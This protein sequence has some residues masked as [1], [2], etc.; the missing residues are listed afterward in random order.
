MSFGFPSFTIF[1]RKNV[2]ELVTAPS[3]SLPTRQNGG[4]NRDM[5]YFSGLYTGKGPMI[6]AK[7]IELFTHWCEFMNSWWNLNNWARYKMLKAYR[8]SIF[9]DFKTTCSNAKACIERLPQFL[10]LIFQPPVYIA[11]FFTIHPS[12]IV[13]NS[14]IISK[15]S[16]PVITTTWRLLGRRHGDRGCLPFTKKF[17]K[18]RLGCKW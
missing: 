13:L 6:L 4:E 10:G 11:F 9:V 8:K 3:A 18:F 17:R 5:V 12:K 7:T 15:I 14:K 1:F 16:F 2:W